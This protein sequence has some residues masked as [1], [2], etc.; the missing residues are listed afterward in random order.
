MR[1]ATEFERFADSYSEYNY[2]QQ[3]VA[4]R[5]VSMIDDRTG[6]RY[7]DIGCG[8]GA[9]YKSMLAQNINIEH[10]IAVDIS[11]SMLKLHPNTDI[12]EKIEGDFNSIELYKSL[13]RYEIDTILSSSSLQWS[14]DI[15]QTIER[16]SR[17]APE[18]AF[19]IFTDATFSDILKYLS[20]S[21]PIH[22]T[23]SIMDGLLKHYLTDTV[24]IE[25]ITMPFEESRDILSYIKKSGVSGG[26]ALL[27][28]R[29]IKNF[30]ESYDKKELEFQIIYFI[31]RSKAFHNL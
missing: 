18:A 10:F 20:V 31:G 9:L 22:S 29:D 21:S 2:I 23:D 24:K 6:T 7:A 11:P 17:I 19:A 26:R 5:L 16:L 3:I 1:A 13:N 27:K 15:N 12:I 4:K 28:Y 14:R 30:I 25:N 8:E